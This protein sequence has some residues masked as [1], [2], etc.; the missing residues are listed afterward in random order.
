[1]AREHDRNSLKKLLPDQTE[2]KRRT[3]H[4]GLFFFA[5]CHFLSI[6]HGQFDTK[7]PDNAFTCVLLSKSLSPAIGVK[8]AQWVFVT[9]LP[10]ERHVTQI[11]QDVDLQI[12]YT[13]RQ[14]IERRERR[15]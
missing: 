12:S 2:R 9:S 1:M 14:E 3:A 13:K 4:S 5:G 6:I 11:A 10:L 8:A 7:L 15:L